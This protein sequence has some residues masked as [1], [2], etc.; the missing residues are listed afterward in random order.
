MGV[1]GPTGAGQGGLSRAIGQGRGGKWSFCLGPHKP[2]AL[3]RLGSPRGLG[4]LLWSSIL[5]G[6]G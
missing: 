5:G 4:F 2:E 6:L 1:A 3:E